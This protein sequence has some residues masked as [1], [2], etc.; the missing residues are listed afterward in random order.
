MRSC[1]LRCNRFA[2]SAHDMRCRLYKMLEF[3][4]LQL[5]TSGCKMNSGHLSTRP[6]VTSDYNTRSHNLLRCIEGYLIHTK[7]HPRIAHPVTSFNSSL[8]VHFGFRCGV[9]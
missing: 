7:M 4:G 5:R 3:S 1:C 6:R 8:V 9:L 2:L